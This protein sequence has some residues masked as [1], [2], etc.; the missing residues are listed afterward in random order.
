MMCHA[1]EI[2]LDKQ[3]LLFINRNS[4]AHNELVNGSANQIAIDLPAGLYTVTVTDSH[5]CEKSSS[6]TITEPPP[7]SFELT[8]QD[9]SCF[10]IH[11]GW[12]KINNISGGIPP[13]LTSLHGDPFIDKLTYANLPSG[14][15]SI[16]AMDKKW[17]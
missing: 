1:M 11:D 4:S 7:L 16:V 15:Y 5:G 13:I 12:I 10:G 3:R 6:I 8:L 9:L 17:M 2:A 14:L